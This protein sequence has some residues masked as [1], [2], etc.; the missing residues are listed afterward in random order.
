MPNLM[1]KVKTFFSKQQYN[2][3]ELIT[4]LVI[5]GL[6]YSHVIGYQQ[7][8][9]ADTILSLISL[10]I[11]VYKLSFI[12]FIGLCSYVFLKPEKTRLL[13]TG[14]IVCG[15]LN[16]YLITPFWINYLLILIF[17]RIDSTLRFVVLLLGIQEVWA[18]L[19]KLSINYINTINFF[20]NS[21]LGKNIYETVWLLVLLIPLLE[22]LA[23]CGILFH[24]KFSNY[25]LI[26]IHG[27][28]IITLVGFLHYNPTVWLWNLLIIVIAI[29]LYKNQIKISVLF[30]KKNIILIT[31]LTLLPLLQ[32][33]TTLLYPLSYRLYTGQEVNLVIDN[34]QYIYNYYQ[35]TNAIPLLSKETFQLDLLKK[36]SIGVFKNA[37]ISVPKYLFRKEKKV[38]FTCE[39]NTLIQ[40]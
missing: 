30:V 9:R 2:L 6:L 8:F 28:A 40:K 21:F 14:M 32:T 10:P 25:L 23:G 5:L 18:G 3:P 20:T 13:I 15:L 19:N 7:W 24:K 27:G 22:I 16:I 39:N 11:I 37:E 33:V 35:T 38:N 26:L 29:L 1:Q 4:R 34:T 36:C 17:I 12:V 31:F